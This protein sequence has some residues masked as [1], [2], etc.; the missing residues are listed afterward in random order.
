MGS[1][2]DEQASLGVLATPKDRR[3]TLLGHDHRVLE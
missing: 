2:F 1:S 3:E